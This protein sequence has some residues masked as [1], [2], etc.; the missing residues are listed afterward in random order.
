MCSV[1][2]FVHPVMCTCSVPWLLAL[3]LS[4]PKSQPVAVLLTIV[5]ILHPVFIAVIFCED[6]PYTFASNSC[7]F[8]VVEY[9]C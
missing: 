1:R 9:V 4:C 8:D 2:C 5:I 7:A 6:F 3:R